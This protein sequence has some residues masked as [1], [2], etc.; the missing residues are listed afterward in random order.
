[1]KLKFLVMALS[2]IVML[3]GDFGLAFSNEAETCRNDL[4]EVVKGNNAFAFDLYASVGAADGNVFLSPFSVAAALAM[5]YA[6]ARGETAVQMEKTLHFNLAP[7]HL[8]HGFASLLKRFNTTDKDYQL[9]VANALWGQQGMEFYPEFTESAN[10]YYDA[11]FN[12]VDYMTNTEAARQTINDWVATKTNQKIIELIKPGILTNLTRLVLTNTIYF[13]GG[14]ESQFDPGQ[15]E[16]A[17]FTVSNEIKSNVPLMR[18]SAYFQYAQTDQLQIVELPYRGDA[19]VMDILLPAFESDLTELESDL[20]LPQF[21]SLL[22]QLAMR[23]VQVWLP[24]FKIAKA[25]RLNDQ[26]QSLGMTDAFDAAKADFSGMAPF[27]LYIT[28]V[29]HNAFVEVTETGSEAA[30]ATGVIMGE[31]ATQSGK[32]V[33][34]RADHPFFFVIRDRHFGSILFMG[35]VV[36]PR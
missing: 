7:V 12:Q 16:E 28:H 5:T 4:A 24:R 14:W 11:G 1:M 22:A 20:Q 31:N 10:N 13:K 32:P 36:D 19:I 6:G 34:F 35:R 2:L 27:S 26:L 29:L 21:Q 8:N 9:A 17:P 33:V 23:E 25:I 30:A 3:A 15:T 18:Q